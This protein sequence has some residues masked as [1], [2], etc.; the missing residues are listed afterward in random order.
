MSNLFF[1]SD[2]HLFHN[3]IIKYT[4]PEFENLDNMRE[5]II[6]L[7]NSVVGKNDTCYIVGD[8]TFSKN[9][10]WIMDRFN[11]KKKLV[12][13]NHDHDKISQY[14]HYFDSVHGMVQIGK[15][16]IITH[17]PIHPAQFEGRFTRNIHGHVHWKTLNDNRYINVSC[18]VLNFLPV[19]WEWIKERHKAE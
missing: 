6:G 16:T 9:K 13:G 4:R 19:S 18:E 8:V 3:N 1:I 2:L 12:L 5:T 11:G 14:G 15:K 10:L 17:C 7:Y